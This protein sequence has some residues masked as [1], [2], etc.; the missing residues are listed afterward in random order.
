M[1]HI[2][3]KLY[4]IP[5]DLGSE[6]IDHIWPGA[7]LHMLAH[8]RHFIVENERS[9]RRFLRKAGYTISFDEVVM[10]DMGKHHDRHNY[11]HMLDA[12]LKGFDTGLMSEAGLPCVADPGQHIVSLAH[13]N[14]I[15]VIPMVG[16]GS[17][18]LALMA[19]GFN[20]QQFSFHGYLP[21]PKQE[22]YKKIAWM[23]NDAQTHGRTQIF[24]E[25]PFRTMQLFNDILHVCRPATRLCVAADITKAEEYIRSKPVAAWKK[26]MPDLHKRPGIFLLYHE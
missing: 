3:G 16:A 13:E 2:S 18:Y 15:Q 20:G 17:I 25:T 10:Y 11:T 19:S 1:T 9:A 24:M 14:G 5:T 4:L 6:T 21:I 26:E 23:E 7:H 22:R 12:A 8:I